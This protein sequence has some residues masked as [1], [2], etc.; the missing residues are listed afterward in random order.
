MTAVID[1]AE[2]RRRASVMMSSS[3]TL[4][5]VGQLVDW[6][7]N[8]STPRTF[9]PISTKLS[10]SLKRITL[11][12][13]SGVSRYCPMA[14]ASSGFALPEKRQT[15]LNTRGPPREKHH[16]SAG[17]TYLPRY[18]LSTDARRCRGDRL[19]DA[20]RVAPGQTPPSAPPVVAAGSAGVAA[21]GRG[22]A[23]PGGIAIRA[24]GR[25]REAP[26]PAGTADLTSAATHRTTATPTT[27]TTYLARR[28][29]RR[30]TFAVIFRRN[31]GWRS[32]SSWASQASDVDSAK[33]R[34]SRSPTGGTLRSA[35]SCS[36]SDSA[37][38]RAGDSAGTLE[39]VDSTAAPET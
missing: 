23:S 7:T 14:A 21:G 18:A 31:C 33:K 24:A 37:S 11:H 9:S 5:L 15:F 28:A 17:I 38:P 25:A 19:K 6:M 35:D 12:L 29:R 30:A 32:S 10:P 26:S 16:E 13:P 36:S 2:A 3:I 8:A 4:S 27:P 22:A 39:A 34:A 20:G 1:P